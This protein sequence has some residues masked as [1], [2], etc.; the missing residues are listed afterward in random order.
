MTPE[1]DRNPP[2]EGGAVGEPNPGYLTKLGQI[3]PLTVKGNGMNE[4]LG[5]VEV[6]CRL[7]DSSR[8]RRQP[9]ASPATPYHGNASREWVGVPGYTRK[10]RHVPGH[11]RRV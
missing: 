6:L 9:P 3:A 8:D 4:L 7:F 1:T 2:L 5:L 11:W 10:G